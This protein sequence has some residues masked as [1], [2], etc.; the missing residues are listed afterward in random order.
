[1]SNNTLITC[2]ANLIS[3]DLSQLEEPFTLE[4]VTGDGIIANIKAGHD[5]ER[6][7]LEI[8]DGIRPYRE[9]GTQL[10]FPIPK[11]EAA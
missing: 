6:L 2:N 4:F 5:G 11:E 1:M 9:R 7:F 10:V 8:K 3:V